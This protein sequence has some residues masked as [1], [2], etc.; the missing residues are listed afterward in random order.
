MFEKLFERKEQ[1]LGALEDTRTENEKLKDFQFDEIVSSADPVKWVEKSPTDWRKFHIR[2]Q[3]GSSSCVAQSM[4]KILGVLQYLRDGVFIDFS[5]AF[6]Y[7]R[8]SNK[9]IGDGEGMI[10]VNAFEIVRKNGT[11]LDALM[12]SQGIS[13]KEINSVREEDYDRVVASAFAVGNYVQFKPK[14]SFDE[15]ASTIQK[16]SKAV[17]TNF[18][19]DRAEWTDIP[20]VKVDSPRLRHSVACVD[21]TLYKGKEYLVIEDSWGKFGKFDGQRLISREFYE[22]RNTFAGY[23]INFK[24]GEAPTSNKPMFA[25]SQ[26][27]KLGDKNDSVRQ[28]QDVLKYEG[29]FPTNVES[30]GLYGA[31]TARA[32]LQFQIKYSVAPLSEL[33][34]LQGRE[35][36]AKTLAKLR[37]LYS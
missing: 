15:V 12:P 9:T 26:Q 4:S 23:P 27:M 2:N 11:T 30:T 33:E 32:V 1:N 29:L 37:E 20:T 7:Q 28:L 21:F 14:L 16:T 22:K 6:I 18:T 25:T 35:V 13:E 3:D 24:L 36:G 31:I 10:A 34:S 8:R 19:F 17:M 5:A